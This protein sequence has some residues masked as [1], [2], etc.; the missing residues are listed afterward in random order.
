[1]FG[2]RPYDSREN[3]RNG[4]IFALVTLGESWHNNHHAF[5]DS[6][7]FGLD[8]YRLDPGY[9]L[10]KL[11]AAVGLAWDVDKPT[12]ERRESRRITRHSEAAAA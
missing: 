5:P 9:W 6:P 8:W 3:S 7:S 12:R 1:M 2:A 11:L 10:I 4:G